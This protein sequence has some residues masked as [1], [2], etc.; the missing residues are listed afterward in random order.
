[1]RWHDGL[2]LVATVGSVVLLARTAFV[3]LRL[4]KARPSDPPVR[5]SFGVTLVLLFVALAVSGTFV[6]TGTQ[7]DD[8]LTSALLLSC[9]LFATI[10]VRDQGRLED[11]VEQ[12]TQALTSA[13]A[14]L[15]N[16][17]DNLP[18][19]VLLA[20]AP[21]GEI[22]L[23]NRKA[24]ELFH[25]APGDPAASLTLSR[26][27]GKPYRPDELPLAR[28]LATGEP[29]GADDVAVPAPDHSL[30]RL[31]ATAA[32][33][34]DETGEM[35][36]AIGVF[37]DVSE[38]ERL[39]ALRDSLT[40]IIVHDLRNP[41]H[42][43]AGYLELMVES[44][45]VARE[46]DALECLRHVRTNCQLLVNMTTALLDLS[47]ME[48][49]EMRLVVREW[50]LAE[51]WAEAY[52]EIAALA[53]LKQL[54]VVDR[55]PDD[56]PPLCVDRSMLRRVLVNLL[57]NAICFA[58]IGST[59]TVAG[60]IEGEQ[61]R[62]AVSDAGPGI[63]PEYRDIIFQK[64]GRVDGLSKGSYLSTGLGLAFCKMAVEV[65]GGRIGVESEV[66]QGSSFWFTV[67]L[68]V[69]LPVGAA[70]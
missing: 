11:L 9:A 47:K 27:D 4:R 48:A 30:V 50:D 31:L 19:G 6:V 58:P 64:S 54:A 10:L 8:L 13:N 60:E 57:T 29:H 68:A 17:L 22:A 56:L 7:A 67:P 62:V 69:E 45:Y 65:Q 40:H 23:V 28:T 12:R 1:M 15:Q 3:L 70:I 18:A 53:Q 49:G 41:L 33:V 25:A 52:S 46:G 35:T 51:V 21:A 63:Q 32:P 38:R 61:V 14:L 55:I 39:R 59:I 16:V 36:A 2:A 26:A 34:R 37:H 42:A 66:G 20:R 43:I 5:I 24:T 44:G